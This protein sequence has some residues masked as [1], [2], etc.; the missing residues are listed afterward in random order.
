MLEKTEFTPLLPAVLLPPAPPP[1]TVTVN[2]APIEN[3]EPVLNPP[4]PPEP[5]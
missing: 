3:D 5:P 2:D 4:A 1:P